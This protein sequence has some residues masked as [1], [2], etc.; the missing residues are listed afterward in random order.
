[1][2]VFCFLAWA[3]TLQRLG[4]VWQPFVRC[5]PGLCPAPPLDP[6]LV[7]AHVP[8]NLL[9]WFVGFRQCLADFVHR[10]V[11]IVV[12]QKTLWHDRVNRVNL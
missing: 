11:D 2:P 12:R 9:C 3:L 1:M 4:V 6:H 7:Y 8:P 10:A 5:E